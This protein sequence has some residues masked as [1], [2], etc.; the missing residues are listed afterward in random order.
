MAAARIASSMSFDLDRFEIHEAPKALTLVIRSGDAEISFD[1][2]ATVDQIRD[3][4]DQYLRIWRD[5]E[6]RMEDA[7]HHLNNLLFRGN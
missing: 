4:C 5:T 2:A 7:A 1:D 6:N 3:M